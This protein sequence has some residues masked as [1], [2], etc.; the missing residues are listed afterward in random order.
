MQKLSHHRSDLK[1]ELRDL[2]RGASGGFLFG[3]PL[4]Y[5]MEVWWIGSIVTPPRMLFSLLFTSLVV[6]G[7][8][9]VAGFRRSTKSKLIDI[10]TDT[11]E[12]QAIGIMCAALLL[13]FL[14]EVSFSSRL[15]EVLGK[16]IFESVPF[17]IGVSLA[18]QFL[19]DEDADSSAPPAS[20]DRTKFWQSTLNDVVAT[21]VG[22]L[23][24]A[25]SIAPTEEVTTLAAQTSPSWLI[26]TILGSLIISYGIVFEANFSNQAKRR[27]HRGLFQD[28]FSETSMSYGISLMVAA[29]MLWFFQ[30]LSL[31]DPATLWLS[32]TIILGLPATIG[33]AAGRL[34]L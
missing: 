29:S 1:T 4:L 27:Q 33:G 13:F 8:N 11:I 26:A 23:I 3:I 15:H 14:Q 22:A 19:Q 12:A 2:I 30:V 24:I 28:P 6:A 5:T 32:C 34:A 10:F 16:V 7:L 31:D 21:I 18:N 20:P 9:Y 25:F 17:S